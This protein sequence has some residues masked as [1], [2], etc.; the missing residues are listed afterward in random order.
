MSNWQSGI[1]LFAT[2]TSVVSSPQAAAV[3]VQPQASGEELFLQGVSKT[4]VED[5]DGAIADLNKAAMEFTRQRNKIDAYKSRALAV[6]LSWADT[7][8]SPPDWYLSGHCMGSPACTY[9]TNWVAPNVNNNN[10]GGILVLNKRIGMRQRSQGG[11]VPI[12]AVL[13]VAVV[14]QLDDG[15]S[16]HNGICKLRGKRDPEIAAIAKFDGYEDQESF[17]EVSQAWRID[18]KAQRISEIPTRGVS[19]VNPCPG[20][21]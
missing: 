5:Y 4:R 13:D 21:C 19:C 18:T 7:N 1:S 20:G 15:E 16:L 8:Q 6:Y 11:S 3:G 9:I 10:Y 14:P 2:L 17:T 12:T